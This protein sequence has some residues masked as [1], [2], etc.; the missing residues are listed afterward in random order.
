MRTSQKPPAET[1]HF[2]HQLLTA[3]CL[4]M[5]SL[6]AS[7][8]NKAIDQAVAHAGRPSQDRD[9]DAQRKPATVLDFFG[10]KPGMQVLIYFP[11]VVITPKFFLT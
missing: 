6:A 2:G 10:I 1:Q 8:G 7:A 4:L 11:A 9:R 3:G 5:L